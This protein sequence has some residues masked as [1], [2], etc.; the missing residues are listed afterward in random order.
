[1]FSDLRKK[2]DQGSEL[3]SFE[4]RIRHEFRARKLHKKISAE[5]FLAEL[6]ELIRFILAYELDLERS[7]KT[8][9]KL[10]SC[11][12]EGET[13]DLDVS[14]K[15]LTISK[16]SNEGHR[17]EVVA[18]NLTGPFF[19]NTDFHLYTF[20]EGSSSKKPSFSLELFW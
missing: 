13:F 3:E 17:I 8:H 18:R 11:S 5:N 4:A 10:S 6:R 1:M 12:F 19:S 7:C 14:E 9:K 16:K 2:S 15:A 20:S